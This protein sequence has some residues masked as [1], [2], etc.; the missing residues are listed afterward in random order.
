MGSQSE[1]KCFVLV[2]LWMLWQRVLAS[3]ECFEVASCF[4]SV[5]ELYSPLHGQLSPQ[6]WMAVLQDLVNAQ[7]DHLQVAKPISS[8]AFSFV[9]TSPLRWAFDP[10]VLNGQLIPV[11]VWCRAWNLCILCWAPPWLG[12]AMPCRGAG[13]QVVRGGKGHM[14][15]QPD[16]GRM[17]PYFLG[18]PYSFVDLHNKL[19][20]WDIK[21][22]SGVGQGHGELPCVAGW[23]E[24]PCFDQEWESVR[25]SPC[26]AASGAEVN[27]V[28]L[29]FQVP[30]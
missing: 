3:G 21:S 14:S 12:L 22:S 28:P 18:E 10:P 30:D 4:V 17:A 8:P 24:I 19:G 29:V 11:C 1:K 27:W 6:D 9:I 20:F 23:K 5:H 16:P 26:I 13:A 7:S 15:L 2:C 25:D